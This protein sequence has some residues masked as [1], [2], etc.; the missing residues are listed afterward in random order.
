MIEQKDNHY[1]QLKT[2]ELYEA[3]VNR[4]FTYEVVGEENAQE[5]CA[6]QEEA[7][8]INGRM[9]PVIG[10]YNHAGYDG[11]TKA[12]HAALKLFGHLNPHFVMPVSDAYAHFHR[13]PAYAAAVWAGERA[14][15]EFPRIVQSYRLRDESLTPE[16]K[17]EL[18]E[19]SRELASAFTS[20]FA[21]R[22]KSGDWF[23]FA[24]EGK[25]NF[26]LL[27]AERSLGNW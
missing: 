27:P 10:Y 3:V 14:G 22:F 16:K 20:S 23:W 19:K 7:M 26:A 13:Q 5:V 6:I 24:P 12:N 1:E 21:E 15:I 18:E 9:L 8:R 17:E 2:F 25:R 4:L 11:P